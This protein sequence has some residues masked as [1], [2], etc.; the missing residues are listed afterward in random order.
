MSSWKVIQPLMGLILS[1]STPILILAIGIY[2]A[3]TWSLYD[4]SIM[5]MFW[6]AF[7]PTTWC[8]AEI[9]EALGRAEEVEFLIQLDKL[10]RGTRA[11]TLLLG[12]VIELI[13]PVL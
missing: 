9:D 13:Q 11:V 10:E 4:E 7:L 2:F 6:C 1:R 3:A 5:R 12:H 8:G